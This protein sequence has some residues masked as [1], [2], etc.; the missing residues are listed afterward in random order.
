[1]EGGEGGG[2]RKGGR[3]AT[4]EGSGREHKELGVGGRRGTL[5]HQVAADTCRKWPERL[6]RSK[7]AT[8]N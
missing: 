7:M 2:G 4:E 3:V 5:D 1:M 8:G 6:R